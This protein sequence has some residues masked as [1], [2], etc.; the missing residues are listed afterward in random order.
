MTI[1][2]VPGDLVLFNSYLPH[3]FRV[4][5]GKENFVLYILI[6]KHFQKKL[7][8]MIIK[9]NILSPNVIDHLEDVV[10]GSNFPWYFTPNSAFADN[11]KSNKGEYHSFSHML[12]RGKENY[13][14]YTNIFNVAAM[15]LQH[16]FDLHAYK[17]FRLR[18]G[19]QISMGKEMINPPH[20]D[21]PVI[22]HKSCILYLN[23]SDGDTCFYKEGK[24][25]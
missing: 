15:D 14:N 17:I 10:L 8:E 9:D 12:A 3:G 19:L 18:L 6:F 24:N 1:D 22:Q 21:D 13:S 11:R 25:F 4:D 20:I 16:K 2:P 5:K 23:N 7:W